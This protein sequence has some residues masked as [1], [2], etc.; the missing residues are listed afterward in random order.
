MNSSLAASRARLNFSSREERRLSLAVATP[1]EASFN[2]V[3]VGLISTPNRQHYRKSRY[4]FRKISTGSGA[5][6][7]RY[8]L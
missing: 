3:S 8:G 5:D 7:Y 2:K 1:T 6:F 4:K